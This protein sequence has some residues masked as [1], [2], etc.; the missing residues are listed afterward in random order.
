MQWKGLI[1]AGTMLPVCGCSRRCG[2]ALHSPEEGA[3]GSR[4][5]AAPGAPGV[6]TSLRIRGVTGT[7]SKRRPERIKMENNFHLPVNYSIAITWVNLGFPGW[8]ANLVLGT[9]RLLFS[10]SLQQHLLLPQTRAS[11]LS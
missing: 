7:E 10:T 4:L 11:E 1:L 2:N 3:P 9:K 5:E 8:T 6:P